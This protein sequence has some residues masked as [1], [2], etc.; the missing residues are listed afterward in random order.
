[1]NIM[2]RIRTTFTAENVGVVAI[3]FG[4]MFIFI[5][6]TV[7]VAAGLWVHLAIIAAVLGYSAGAYLWIW[8]RDPG[9]AV[10]RFKELMR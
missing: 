2:Q 10:R 8:R 9:Y 1:M 4:I 3:L 7:V 6:T 5:V